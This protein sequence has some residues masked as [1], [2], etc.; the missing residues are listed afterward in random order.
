L[1]VDEISTSQ[2]TGG[3]D[4]DGVGEGPRV[5]NGSL[6]AERRGLDLD[7]LRG[8]LVF[9]G[10]VLCGLSSDD[11]GL[12]SS[13]SY[14]P[15]IFGGRAIRLNWGEVGLVLTFKMG[16]RARGEGGVGGVST[17]SLML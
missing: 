2:D 5:G 12:G 17:T 15:G 3:L 8:G 13:S 7:F 6:D 11:E 1:K 16:R 4:I 9:C 14:I 10:L